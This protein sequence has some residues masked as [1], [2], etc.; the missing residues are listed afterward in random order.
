MNKT[1]SDIFENL[2]CL[3]INNLAASPKVA[4]KGVDQKEKK[5]IL[6]EFLKGPIPLSWLTAASNLSGKAS[7]AVGLAIWF[8]SG[9]R[10]SNEVKLTTA[11]VQRFAVKRKSKYSALKLL[12]DAGLIRVRREPRKNP[13]VTILEIMSPP[14]VE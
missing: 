4:A 10:K 6:G 2:D 7:L 13:V 14:K 3:K 11:I 8:E 12:E 1:V 5:K 9:R